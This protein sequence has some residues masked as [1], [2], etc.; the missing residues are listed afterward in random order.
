MKN[1]AF[2]SPISQSNLYIFYQKY[3]AYPKH[4]CV[5]AFKEKAFNLFS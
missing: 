3:P 5:T 2:Y 1:I 4:I